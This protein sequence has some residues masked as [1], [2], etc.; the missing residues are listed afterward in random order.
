MGRKHAWR[1]LA[2]Q[3]VGATMALGLVLW[4]GCPQPGDDDDD[5]G[6]GDDDDQAF[7]P[8]LAESLDETLEW[9]LVEHDSPGIAASIRLADGTS[10]TGAAGLADVEQQT[11]LQPGDHFKVAS[12]TKTFA[13]AVIL[14]LVGEGALSLDDTL[15]DWY[16]G[17]GRGDEI[18]LRQ[19]LQ[20]TSGIP[21]FGY[22]TE[23]ITN[24]TEPWT[25]EELVACV[26]GDSLL[27]DPGTGY[28]YSNTNYVL[29]S[30]VIEA[31]T[32]QG[33]AAEVEQRL[34]DPLALGDTRI[35]QDSWGDIVAGYLDDADM[36]E[37]AHPTSSG[38]AGSMVANAGDVARWG[39]A[40][41]GGDVLAP[42][43]SDARFDDPVMLIEDVYTYGLGVMILTLD[44][45]TE[46]GHTGASAGYSAWVGHLPDK[47]ATIAVLGNVWP[48]H[49]E[50]PGSYD[51]D[52]TFSAA[53]SLWDVVWAE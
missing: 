8:A 25:A 33:W 20:H 53:Q 19:L 41:F 23:W 37:D 48:P 1:G 34:L 30:L 52:W 50:T 7:D 21:E 3:I 29:L 9:L 39:A 46:W 45:G 12:V 22:T 31:A 27:F 49:P 11:L 15:E 44:H 35:P 28:S 4:A 47:G 13:A 26:D 36:S 24:R 17:F 2:W 18:T 51:W 32:G 40:Y 10:W 16:P 5:S 6:T 14:Q 42:S 38:A 43:E